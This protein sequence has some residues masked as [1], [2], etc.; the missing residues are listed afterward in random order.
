MELMKPCK[1]CQVF[2]GQYHAPGCPNRPT[3]DTDAGD[4]VDTGAG[5]GRGDRCE[6]QGDCI[7]RTLSHGELGGCCGQCEGL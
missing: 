2:P 6:C 7:K 1:D 4:Q 5:T 3:V